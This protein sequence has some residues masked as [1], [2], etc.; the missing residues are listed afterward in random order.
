MAMTSGTDPLDIES[1][2]PW[3]QN[4][5]AL[6][7]LRFLVARLVSISGIEVNATDVFHMDSQQIMNVVNMIFY[8][9]C[10]PTLKPQMWNTRPCR[11]FAKRHQGMMCENAKNSSFSDVHFAA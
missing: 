4:S 2:N 1:D 11:V 9:K 6:F 10:R 3:V 7:N 8:C 5:A